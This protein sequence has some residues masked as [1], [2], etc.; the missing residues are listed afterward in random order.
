MEEDIKFYN[1][2]LIKY[3]KLL[4]DSKVV[5]DSSSTYY[6]WKDNIFDIMNKSSLKN[7]YLKS[8]EVENNTEYKTK[9]ESFY[10]VVM[11]IVNYLKRTTFLP[12]YLVM[13]GVFTGLSGASVEILQSYLVT[14]LNM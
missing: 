10:M 13:L 4:K 11:D 2:K 12:V 1:M 5:L 7:K 8:L 6:Q 9:S 14:A 3:E